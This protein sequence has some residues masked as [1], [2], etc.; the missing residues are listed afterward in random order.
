MLGGRFMG[1]YKRLPSIKA[2]MMMVIVPIIVMAIAATVVMAALSLK[3]ALGYQI[4][5]STESMLH[6]VSVS[7]EKELSIHRKLAE[8][9]A[10]V[11]EAEGNA[12]QKSAYKT[13]IEQML[14]SSA[15]TFGAGVWMSYFA[16]NADQKYFGP[17]V[18]KEGEALVYTED[19][20]DPSY[21]YPNTDWY[22][23]GL[24]A[25]NGVG[26][27][28]PFYDEASDVTM[29]TAAVPI[30]VN[31]KAI[32][33]A[34][35]DYDLTT[36]QTMVANIKV[37]ETGYAFLITSDGTYLAHQDAAKVM[38][39]NIKD[40]V[41]FKGLADDMLTNDS[42]SDL[43]MTNGKS[44][45]AYFTTLESTGW[46]I[47]I[48]APTTELYAPVNSTIMKLAI[49]GIVIVL[50]TIIV[51]SIYSASI[52][53]AIAD[54]VTKLNIIAE[55]DFTHQIN[56]VSRDE[57]GQMGEHYNNVISSLK[58]M[59]Y[60]ISENAD[61]VAGTAEELA[62]TSH[63]AAITSDEVAQT[64]EEI[65]KGVN[66]QAQDVEHTASNVEALGQ[67]FEQNADYILKL[68]TAAAKIE[69]QKEDGFVILGELI[70]K[71]EE[72]STAAVNVYDIILSN[73]ESAEK[74]ESASEMI[75]NIADQTN[76]LAL[77]AAIEAAR[78]GEAGRGFAVVADEIRKL[79]EQSNNFTNDIKSV[80]E[81]LKNKSTQAVELMQSTKQIVEEQAKSVKKTEDKFNGIADAIDEINIVIE[82]LNKLTT[83]MN[84]NKNHIIELT[85][86]LSAVSEENAAG[87]EEASAAMA[88]Q[89][90]SIDELAKSG[91]NLASVAEEL[92]ILI[93]RFK[94]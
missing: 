89:A 74:I 58:E 26:W 36:I 70:Q 64:I 15:N 9:L 63:Q 1:F 31:N 52:A 85:E 2:K 38:K 23:A 78:A 79:A 90:A 49:L 37:A 13:I 35:A 11:Y 27:T 33:V 84:E 59:V 57:I 93:E 32:G 88:A 81:S 67:L 39:M 18:Y 47:A 73:N 20:E 28:D 10:A 7:A 76:L 25:S 75:Q 5:L 94:V 19:Y 12:L 4:D 48:M 65:A 54:F 3:N 14:P 69:H 60:T 46:K 16:Y 87:T 77:N 42:G 17:Y 86:N 66:N 71:T 82:A 92:K 80:I 43:V 72:N 21:D 44:Y 62:A 61:S 55:G 56:V 51:I 40:D 45:N 29:F 34:S 8:T 24:N 91:E 83:R 53:K 68:N 41:A 22:L 6:E 30:I 50:L